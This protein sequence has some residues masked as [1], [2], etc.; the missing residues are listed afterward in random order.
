MPLFP[1]LDV[2]AIHCQLRRIDS[3]HKPPQSFHIHKDILLQNLLASGSDYDRLFTGTGLYFPITRQERR[4][5][6]LSR[7]RLAAQFFDGCNDSFSY[8]GSN[9]SKV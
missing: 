7:C 8:T 2:S 6:N 5:E 4:G 3:T 9:T 1:S